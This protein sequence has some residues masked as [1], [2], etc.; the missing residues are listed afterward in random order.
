M[1]GALPSA[2]LDELPSPHC[3]QGFKPYH[4]QLQVRGFSCATAPDAQYP[5][6]FVKLSRHKDVNRLRVAQAWAHTIDGGPIVVSGDKTEGVEALIKE[7]KAHT[8]LDGVLPKSHGKVFW[9]TRS[10]ANTPP[11]EWLRGTEPTKNKDGFATVAG[12][13]SADKIDE[14]SKLLTAHLD[15]NTKGSVADLGAGWG[16]L[17]KHLLDL[18]PNI[19]HLD[20]FEA[21]AAALNVAKLNVTDPRAAFHWQDVPNM[22]GFENSYDLVISN[23]PFHETRKSEPH[24]GQKFIEK[25]ARILKR[26]GTFLMVANRQLPY[27]RVLQEQFRT[28]EQVADRGGYKVIVARNPLPV[29]R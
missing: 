21:E 6:S 5:Q 14:G 10:A 25:A 29:K 20:L 24:L 3:I 11:P 8:T 22:V 9:L 23:P 2:V 19:S 18:A 27:E 4:D 15:K 26:S 13:F 16:Y 12:V 17:S 28:T 7:L 1:I